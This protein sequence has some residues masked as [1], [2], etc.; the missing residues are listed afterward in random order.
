MSVNNIREISVDSTSIN[1]GSLSRIDKEL[2]E[3]SNPCI[4]CTIRQDLVDGIMKLQKHENKFEYILIESTGVSESS[5]VAQTFELD[6]LN[7]VAKLGTLIAIV[8]VD[9]KNMS[10]YIDSTQF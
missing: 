4:C 8:H 10:N 2:I 7:D 9:C 1:Q 3:L 6:G 5:P